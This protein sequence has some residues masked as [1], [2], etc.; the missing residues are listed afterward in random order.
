[1]GIE[2]MDK[3]EKRLPLIFNVSFKPAYCLLVHCI[4]GAFHKTIGKHKTILTQ[5]I[6]PIV[7]LEAKATHGS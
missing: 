4:A 7:T 3:K 1:M 6:L 2:V 5:K